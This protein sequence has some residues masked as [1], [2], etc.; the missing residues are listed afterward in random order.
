MNL[1]EI[2]IR[3]YGRHICQHKNH[4]LLI[5]KESV[6]FWENQQVDCK[7][8]SHKRNVLAFPPDRPVFY[9]VSDS[10][11]Y[12]FMGLQRNTLSNK[13]AYPLLPRCFK[14]EQVL[15][16]KINRLIQQYY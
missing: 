9:F 15:S 12:P 4:I 16:G 8:V 13:E 1:N 10:D 6:E 7:G 2:F 5:D 14:K 3:G 11:E